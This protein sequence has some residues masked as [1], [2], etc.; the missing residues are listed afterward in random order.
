MNGKEDEGI[1]TR[2]QGCAAVAYEK[3]G[4]CYVLLKGIG[5]GTS[6]PEATAP[7]LEWPAPK[8]AYQAGSRGNDMAYL[9]HLMVGL[10]RFLFLR[11][12]VA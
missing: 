10:R 7:H 11:N 8:Q 6:W 3:K 1:R 5:M 4:N 2:V 9:A 12:I